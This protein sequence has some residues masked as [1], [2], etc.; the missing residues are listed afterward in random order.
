MKCCSL[1]LVI[2]GG[3]ASVHAAEILVNDDSE[4]SLR[5]AIDGASPGD[6]IKFGPA[7]SDETIRLNGGEI[8][9]SIDLTFDASELPEGLTISGENTG[10]VFQILNTATVVFDSI[11][12][13]G[14]RTGSG[15][16][17]GGILNNG[18]N[19]TLRRVTVS[20][21]TSGDGM[22]D[23]NGP[24]SPGGNGGGIYNSGTLT[25]LD[26]T[27]MEN[28]TGRG[29]MGS[30]LSGGPPGGNGAGIYNAG[31]FVTIEN[32]TIANNVGG[33]G[34]NA[35]TGGQGG[36]GGGI[37]NISSGTVTIRNSTIT[38][39]E[40]GPTGGPGTPGG[41]GGG[42][43][44]SSGTVNLSN[45]VVAENRLGDSGG[46][47]VNDGADIHP[48]EGTLNAIGPNLIGDNDQVDSIFPSSS[49]LVGTKAS[50]LSPNLAPLPN[51]SGS[52]PVRIPNVGSPVIEAGD[53]MQLSSD[54]LDQDEDNDF[55]ELLPL[56]QR[57]L[58]RISGPNVDL[59]SVEDQLAYPALLAKKAKLRKQISAVQKL[60]KK[61]KRAKKKSKLKTLTR[62]LKKLKKQLSRL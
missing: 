24:G 58:P 20:G 2:W 45:S 61:A 32:S 10:R 17:G 8:T 38:G 3:A 14:G 29:G 34:G 22:S 31:G 59:G 19:L 40:S 27:I 16:I 9:L 47:D 52:P 6:V 36:S 53:N 60:I 26:S 48:G 51:F 56:D 44:N 4:A 50:P 43:Y 25:I 35:S 62:K 41:E 23:I 55:S 42:I 33:Q 11:R 30:F 46:L 18:G 28:Q 15:G 54:G 1:Y 12:I 39:N 21:N 49:R 13:T 37:Y 5:A 7:L 57:G